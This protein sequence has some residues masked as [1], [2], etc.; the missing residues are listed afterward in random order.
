M[1]ITSHQFDKRV[2][3]KRVTSTSNVNGQAKPVFVNYDEFWAR[4]QFRE[5]KRNVNGRVESVSQ[6]PI[7][8]TRRNDDIK[9]TDVLE[10]EGKEYRIDS[11][12]PT[13]N[14]EYTIIRAYIDDTE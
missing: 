12:I 14:G 3:Q 1:I 11:A 5:E 4:L 6:R 13:D 8:S 10:C 9:K 7:F 2:I